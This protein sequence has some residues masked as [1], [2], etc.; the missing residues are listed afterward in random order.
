M[1]THPAEQRDELR[2]L[3]G[4]LDELGGLAENATMTGGLEHGAPAAVRRYNAIVERLQELDAAPRGFS[5]LG[6]EASFDESSVECK[7]LARSLKEDDRGIHGGSHGGTERNLALVA[8]LAPF[9]EQRELLDLLRL[10]EQAG[11]PVDP[12]VILALAPFLPKDEITRLVRQHLG[13]GQRE[14]GQQAT[15]PEPRPAS[16]EPPASPGAEGA[17]RSV[18]SG[19]PDQRPRRA[20]ELDARI[21]ELSAALRQAGLTEADRARLAGELARAA[22]ERAQPP[23]DVE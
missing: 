8:G 10:H 3:R 20:A 11:E 21:D 2:R 16:P 15:N 18:A 23:R 13:L 12:A 5:P 17:T 6:G 14:K 9:V 4:M 19:E 22:G 7:V 1:T